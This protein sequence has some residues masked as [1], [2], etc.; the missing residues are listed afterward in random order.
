MASGYV[1]FLEKAKFKMP[2]G[3][4]YFDVLIPQ[5]KFEKQEKTDVEVCIVPIESFSE[6]YKNPILGEMKNKIE[7]EYG[8]IIRRVVV[9]LFPDGDSFLPYHRDNEAF[10][11]KGVFSV[12]FGETRMFLTKKG[13]ETKRYQI[14]DGDM[15][16]FNSYFDEEYTHCTPPI[17]DLKGS[18][19]IT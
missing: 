11:G 8:E 15:M 18:K 13:S 14:E 5:L 9:L 7:Q 17:K 3:F 10:K 6:K 19:E 2:L 12:S 4:S 16:F 1:I